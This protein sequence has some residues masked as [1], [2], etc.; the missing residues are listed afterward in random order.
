MSWQDAVQQVGMVEPTYPFVQWLNDGGIL[1]P[2][3]KSGGFAMPESEAAVAGDVPKGAVRAVAR[4]RTADEAVYFAP[5]IRAAILAVRFTWTKDGVPLPQYVEGARGKA[6]ALALIEGERGPFVAVLTLSGLSSRDFLTA[7]K[8]HKARVRKITRASGKE[9][10]ASIFYMTIK[11]GET[12]KMAQGSVRTPMVLS[13]DFVPD[14]DYIGEQAMQLIPWDEVKTW[15][16][17][18]PAVNGDDERDEPQPQEEQPLSSHDLEWALRF[19]SP[20]G[21]KSFQKGTPL[22]ELPSQAVQYIA[23]NLADKYPDAARAARVILEHWAPEGD[24]PF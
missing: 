1:S 12:Q 19:P 15:A 17:S 4:F 20:V 18:A 14:Q 11:A 21:G 22:G 23:D 16:S 24:L 5:E 2:R 6:K 10:P 13:G 9:A 8:E 7:W 3:S